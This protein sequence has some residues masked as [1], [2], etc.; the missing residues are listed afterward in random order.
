[1]LLRRAIRAR[2]LR[3]GVV[4][5]QLASVLVGVA[6][7]AAMVAI[8]ENAQNDADQH[9]HVQL[10]IEQ[11]RT[12]SQELVAMTWQSL[13]QS[14]V[15]GQ[16]HL[17][18]D[19]ALVNMGWQA[20]RVL[21]TAVTSLGRVNPGPQARALSRDA[22]Q[23]FAAGIKSLAI[24][25]QGSVTAV[26]AQVN[27]VFR[28]LLGRLDNDAS[29]AARTEQRVA[30]AASSR[31]NITYL[32]SLAVGLLL[33][34]LLGWQLHRA[35]RGALIAEE[36]RSVERRAEERVR[37]LVEHATDVITVVD[38]DL[39]V[40]WQSSSIESTLGL[41]AERVLGKRLTDGVHPNDRAAVES[42]FA[43]VTSRPGTL[44]FS[45][46]F[47]H[48]DGTW[49]HLE[50][51]AANRLAGPGIGGIVLSMRDI[52]DRKALEDELRHQAFHDSLTGL[53]NKALFEDRLAHALAG[54]RRHG[55]LV[56]VL[57]LDLDDF[58]T[59]NDSLGHANGDQLL[60][61]VAL[62]IAGVVRV[63]DT[64]ARLGGDEFAVLVEMVDQDTEPETIA[65]RLLEALVPTFEI[66]GREL[67]V[68]ASIGLVRTDGSVG[69]DELLRDADTAMNVAKESGKNTV[70]VFE[71]GMHRRVLER[72]EMTGQLQRAL[73]LDE[74]VLDYQPIVKLDCGTIIGVEALVR[75]VHPVRGRLGPGAFIPLAE[76]TGLIVPL[77]EW[78]LR[79]ACAQAADWR[80]SFSDRQLCMNVNVSTRQLRDP[81]FLE[82]VAAALD[83]S[84]L[85][86]ELLVL[87]ITESLLPDDSDGIIG[88]LH[89][90]KA[91]GVRIA[92]DD[93]GTG[94]SALSRLQSYP[95]DILKIDRSF[96]DGLEHDDGKLQLV[97]GI[98]S[99]GELLQLE[100]VAEGIEEHEQ[101]EQLRR[102]RSQFGQGYLF[103]R[104]VAR[105]HI[106]AMLHDA[107]RLTGAVPSPAEAA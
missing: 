15:G 96:I 56:A 31:A 76:E 54:A 105:E 8:S 78:I 44:T 47:R 98:V 53:A 65:E 84:G 39:R 17:V 29:A 69:V 91:L 40:R 99:L 5:R 60:R 3:S 74:F 52:T 28:P 103:S 59:I 89:K 83:D 25:R 4:L 19:P 82:T 101:A 37:A 48:V 85:E 106:H 2:R 90:L 33:L 50:A 12:V 107:R 63:T 87:E 21:Q 102:V 58:K 94:Y 86:R 77:G 11:I 67:R 62:R 13:A 34:A 14:W 43:L 64:A 71:E 16:Q 93:F 20:W 104:P 6:V 55:Q 10:Q 30:A 72:L 22:D 92:V 70:Q 9:R 38:P 26:M 80:R 24:M 51:V 61:G 81:A 35:Q 45:A 36:R 68:S 46:R 73:E 100:V 32:A 27:G 88:Q 97:R 75:W 42:H 57:F 41:D 79:T 7:I 23:V 66:A 95:V 49:R 1:M 18:D